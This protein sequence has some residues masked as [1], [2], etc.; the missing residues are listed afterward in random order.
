[1]LVL[2]RKVDESISVGEDVRVIVVAITA[3]QVKLGI[4]A[5]PQ[6]SIRRSET[7]AAI[8]RRRTSTPD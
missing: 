7:G 8:R 3:N 1:M 2:S 5:P 6:L 4:E